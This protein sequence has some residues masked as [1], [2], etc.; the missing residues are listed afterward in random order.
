MAKLHILSADLIPETPDFK[1]SG[2]LDSVPFWQNLNFFQEF[3]QENLRSR[4][5]DNQPCSVLF[6]SY[7]RA[8]QGCFPLIQRCSAL[9]KIRHIL[10]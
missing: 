7:L 10:V 8:V 5:R 3:S 2:N 9:L 6:Q 4:F 1:L